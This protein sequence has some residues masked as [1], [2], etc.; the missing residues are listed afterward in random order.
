M[1]P[2]I[3][4]AP[5]GEWEDGA[6]AQ[7]QVLAETKEHSLETPAAGAPHPAATTG[8]AI[9][10]AAGAAFD[11]S[12]MRGENR[13]A[14]QAAA[15]RVKSL[16]A[17][18]IVEVGK[19]LITAKKKLSGRFC[20]WIECEFRMS[21]STALNYMRVAERFADRFATVA[22]LPPA[23]LYRLA[24]PSTPID[25]VDEVIALVKE[26]P[27]APPIERIEAMV[28]NARAEAR[29]PKAKEKEKQETTE[30][31]HRTQKTASINAAPA[32]A[33]PVQE[34]C[35]VIVRNTPPAPAIAA[36]PSPA[37]RDA[38][39]EA[40]AIVAAFMAARPQVRKLAWDR[41]WNEYHLAEAEPAAPVADDAAEGIDASGEP[42]L[43]PTPT[44][45][46]DQEAEA[47]RDPEEIPSFLRRSPSR[48][49]S[50]NVGST[51][52]P[53]ESEALQ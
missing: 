25:T 2:I 40:D 27:A 45:A 33:T 14:L 48:I 30:A 42:P 44:A 24:A 3:G 52:A 11:Y 35:E 53:A 16:I 19:E 18:S 8:I 29:E 13:R 43:T 39:A 12:T 34:Q 47:A 6:S 7:R 37:P 1:I 20:D 32:A 17:G 51:E 46:E 21:H 10:P 4:S 23:T 41:L 22:N 28:S 38:A 5:A 26:N 36:S 31:K 49:L 15:A 50:A 9:T